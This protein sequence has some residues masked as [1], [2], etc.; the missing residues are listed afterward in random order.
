MLEEAKKAVAVLSERLNTCG[1]VPQQ[2]DEAV[3]VLKQGKNYIFFVM[4]ARVQ[5]VV[6]SRY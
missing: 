5:F 3:S 4:L 1:V 6:L 2:A